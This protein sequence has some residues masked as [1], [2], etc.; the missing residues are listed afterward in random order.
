MG[1]NLFGDVDPHRAPCDTAPAAYTARFPE[2]VDPRG[3]LVSHP[4][5][6]SRFPRPPYASPVEVRKAGCKTGVPVPP[7]LGVISGHVTHV[8]HDRAEA[9]GAHHGA[10]AASQASLRDVVPPR[11]LEV[12]I[13]Q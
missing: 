8:L 12:S 2:L 11:M 7:A 6:V 13:Q 1:G 3:E 4:L 9:S 5:A 10:V